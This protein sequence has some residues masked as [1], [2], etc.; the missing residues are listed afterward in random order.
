MQMC[1]SS[2]YDQSAYSLLNGSIIL[3]SIIIMSSSKYKSGCRICTPDATAALNSKHN[4]VRTVGA[5]APDSV[6]LNIKLNL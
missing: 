6:R 4:T 1:L 2:N 5:S 3:L